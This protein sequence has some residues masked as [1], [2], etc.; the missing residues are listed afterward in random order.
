MVRTN[1]IIAARHGRRRGPDQGHRPRAGDV[2]RRQRALLLSRSAPRRDARRRRSGAQRRLR[3]RAAARRD[4]LPELRQPRAA[5]DHVAVRPRRSKASAHACRALDVPITGG[6]VSLYNETDGNGDLS[7]AGH[8]RRR[9]ARARRPRRRP[10]AFQ[11][12][13]DAIVLL[14]EGR[15]ELGGSEYLKVVHGLVRGDAA[16]ARP[17]SRSARCSSLLVDACGRAAGPLGARLLR[18]RPCGDA[19][20]MLLRHRWCRRRDVDRRG[21]VARADALDGGAALFG[22]SASRI[23][24]SVEP[25]HESDV[26]SRASAAG[27]PARFGLAGRAATASDCRRWPVRRRLRGRRKPNGSGPR[28][29]SSTSEAR[30]LSASKGSHAR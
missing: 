7:D 29:S 18:R 30:G 21:A 6:N 11:G 5:G 14:G 8:R 20:R 24:V 17:R 10:R 13:G 12:A 28:R 2:G 16:G 4:Q 26:L 19:G 22:E 15:G 3:R 1:T 9:P 27:V 25:R 23:V